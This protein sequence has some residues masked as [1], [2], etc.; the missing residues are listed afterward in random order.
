MRKNFINHN[1]SK[2][3]V[4][5]FIIEIIIQFVNSD[6]EE[7]CLY[8]IKLIN[9]DQIECVDHC[10][11]DTCEIGD[12]CYDPNNALVTE[13]LDTPFKIC[14]CKYKKKKIQLQLERFINVL[15]K[16]MYAQQIIIIQI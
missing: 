15:M 14:K 9:T 12:Y 3:Y 11:E 16:I 5:I 10:P 2:Y 6:N 13:I 4:F 7:E 8:K 1:F